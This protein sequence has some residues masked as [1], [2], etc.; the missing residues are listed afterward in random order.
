MESKENKELMQKE[1]D[2]IND[3]PFVFELE[4]KKPKTIQEKKF[5][6]LISTNKTIQEKVKEEFKIYPLRLSTMNRMAKYQLDLR[7]NESMFKEGNQLSND[8]NFNEMKLIAVNNTETMA[9]IV[10]I[11][12]LG[13]DYSEKKFKKVKQ[14]MFDS[15][16]SFKLE[17]IINEI[18][19]YQH[20]GNFLNST[21]AMSAR[22]TMS[23]NEV[24]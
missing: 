9:S 23:P 19:R 11:A 21:V 10:A 17:V 5:F 13:I 6:G 3:V 14:I 20:L 15:L 12:V 22:T 2:I 7:I 8:D 18:L 16:T 4:Y 24:E 1:T